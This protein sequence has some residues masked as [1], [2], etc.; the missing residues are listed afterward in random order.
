MR[1]IAA[2]LLLA[3][4]LFNM[5]GYCLLFSYLETTAD[6]RLEQR[7][8]DGNYDV[9]QLQRFKIPVKLPYYTNSPGY[10]RK[11]GQFLIDGRFMHYVKLRIYHDTLDVYCIPDYEAAQ[12][13]TA[14]D[15]FFKVAVNL[16]QEGGNKRAVPTEVLKLFSALYILQARLK[17]PCCN[18]V[19]TPTGVFAQNLLSSDFINDIY[20]PPEHLSSYY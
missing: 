5:G 10:E 4:L 9:S 15:E 11:D 13:Q 18:F 1:R 3:V 20:N 2:I 7:L 8:D 16:E 12:L 19:T 6:N 14:K 17:M